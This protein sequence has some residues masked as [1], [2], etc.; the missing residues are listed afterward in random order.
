MAASELQVHTRLRLDI[1]NM[2][3][4]IE[5]LAKDINGSNDS[6]IKASLDAMIAVDEDVTATE[7]SLQ[8]MEMHLQGIRILMKKIRK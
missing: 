6:N 5:D 3:N 1:E 2:T 7:R 8:R 4:A